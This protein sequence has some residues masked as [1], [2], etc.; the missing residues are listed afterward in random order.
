[1]TGFKRTMA[2]MTS[3]DDWA[4]RLKRNSTSLSSGIGA[5]P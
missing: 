4:A 3:A 1:M 5:L 2:A